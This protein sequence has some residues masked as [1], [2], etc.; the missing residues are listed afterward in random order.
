VV[1]VIAGNEHSNAVAENVGQTNISW[2][3]AL[4]CQKSQCNLRNCKFQIF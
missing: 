4:L 1:K 2:T 3:I